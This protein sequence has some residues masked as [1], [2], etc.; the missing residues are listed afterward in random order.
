M[1]QSWALASC[2]SMILS[3]LPTP[4]EASVDAVGRREGFAQPGNRFPSPIAVEDMLFGI[5]L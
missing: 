4:A 2:L 3:D 1:N 5:M